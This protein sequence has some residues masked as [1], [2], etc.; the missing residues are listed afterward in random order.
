MLLLLPMALGL[1][2]LV[3]EPSDAA[4]LTAAAAVQ[5]QPQGAAAAAPGDPLVVAA[6][7][8]AWQLLKHSCDA[9]FDE[10]GIRSWP[11]G[12]TIQIRVP[13]WKGG[14][15]VKVKSN[16]PRFHMG[17]VW[18]AALTEQTEDMLTFRLNANAGGI[19]GDKEHDLEFGFMADITADKPFEK[20]DLEM[21][22][23]DE[24]Q[25]M[26]PRPPPNP[27]PPPSPPTP[28]PPKLFPPPRS[29][30]PPPP[31]PHPSPLPPPPAP[32]PAP[33]SPPLPVKA[34]RPLS[35]GGQTLAIR[36]AVGTVGIAALILGVGALIMLRRQ[37]TGGAGSMMDGLGGGPGARPKGRGRQG[38]TRVSSSGDDGLEA[39][40]EGSGEGSEDDYSEGE[41]GSEG[42]QGEE[43]EEA[44]DDII[45][46]ED[47]VAE[48]P[49][50]AP[51]AARNAMDD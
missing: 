16:R 23:V 10:T 18:N 41:E 20:G 40:E 43:K 5:P 49:A 34:A 12:F 36:I 38:A 7:P 30:S 25:S 26:M 27:P 46:D 19:V 14:Q 8:E 3:A 21:A 29:P 37:A 9:T 15:F 35:T 33:Y 47:A 42:D 13:H 31:P 50:P 44:E 1:S 11:T 6:E 39:A 32:P 2:Q 48:Q 17:Q 22:V 24:C 28:P 4:L 51:A 45:G